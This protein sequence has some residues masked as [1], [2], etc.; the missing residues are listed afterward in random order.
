MAHETEEDIQGR[1]I[2][3]I[4]EVIDA[5]SRHYGEIIA[6]RTVIQHIAVVVAS[7]SEPMRRQLFERLDTDSWL[8]VP[9]TDDDAGPIIA[10]TQ[11][12]YK[13]M[14][15]NIRKDLLDLL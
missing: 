15:Q 13:D 10:A 1:Q 8:D 7:Q 9:N 3:L 14:L 5:Q 12:C 4:R 6:I 2:A 11:D